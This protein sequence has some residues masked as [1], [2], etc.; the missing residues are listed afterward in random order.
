MHRLS[1]LFLLLCSLCFVLPLQAEPVGERCALEVAQAFFRHDRNVARRMAPVQPVSLASAPLTKAGEAEPAFRVFNRAGG[2]FVIIAGDDACTPVLA[3]SFEN[4]FGTGGEMPENLR[5]WLDELENLVGFARSQRP[6]DARDKALWEAL[7]VQTKAGGDYLPAVKLDTPLW[8]QTEPFNLLTPVVDGKHTVTGC[9]P[10]AMAMI[11]RFYGYPEKGTGTLNPYSYSLDNGSNC[12]IDGFNLGH[13]Y[14]W[15]KI[16]FDYRN[17]YTEEEGAAVARL[18]Y[19]CGVAVQAKFDESTSAST[20]KMA[21]CAVDYFGYDPGAYHYK[22]DLFTDEQWLDMIKAE[23]QERPILYSAKRDGG[24]HAFLVDGYDEQGYVSV[25][26]G[27]GGASNGYYVLSAFSPSANRQYIYNHGAVFGLKPKE[28][29]G[30]AAQEYLYYQGGTSSSSGTV[31]NGL[32]PSETIRP[33]RAFTMKA[34][35]LY[36]GGIKSFSGEYCIVLCDKDGQ[37][38]EEISSISEFSDLSAGSG[39]GYPSINC[40]MQSYPLEG[41]KVCLVYRSNNWPTGVWEKP[42]YDLT[43]DLVAEIP[44]TDGTKLEEVTSFNY[45]KTTGDV[46]I[47]TKDRVDWRLENA[48]GQVVTEGVTYEMTALKIA[49][50]GLAKGTYQ[51]TLKRLDEQLT[52]TLKMGSK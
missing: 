46:M 52:L 25:N 40:F 43:S 50:S 27:W 2:G 19:D 14:E 34:G 5:E 23:V 3:Y 6:A 35:F 26:W 32:T 16:K 33:G 21:G 17:G 13:P 28:A 38:K 12:S 7:F 8:T 44:V 18:V 42:L 30:G 1:T 39:R 47:Q 29:E 22:R 49:T 11:M 20:P 36:N 9:V 51:L 10:L 15:N 45:N 24:G 41:D 31:Y 4:H 48:S 37:I